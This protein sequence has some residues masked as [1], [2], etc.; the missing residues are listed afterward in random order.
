LKLILVG[1]ELITVKMAQSKLFLISLIAI[2]IANISCRGQPVF[3]DTVHVLVYETVRDAA[4]V[5]TLQRQIEGRING[6][7][8]TTF[9]ESSRFEGF[10]NKFVSV[11]P[12]LREMDKDS[13]VVIA[14][15]RDVLVNN[16]YNDETY[17]NVL[18]DEFKMTFEELTFEHPG[19][20]VVSAE[21][22]CCVV[23]LT[24]AAPGSYFNVD[25]TRNQ[26]ACSSGEP[27]CQWNGDDKAAPWEMFMKNLML[28]RTVAD[29][30]VYDDMYLNA[31]LIAGRAKDLIRV[32]EG[33][34]M[35]KS[36][37]DQA[38]LTDYMFR[39]PDEIML[40]YGQKMFGNN[41]AGVAGLSQEA[42]CIFNKPSGESRL[43]H[44]ETGTT[45]LFVHS[46]G[47]FYECHDSLSNVLGIPELSS[48]E[49][50]LWGT[51]KKKKCNYGP[52]KHGLE[53][54]L[55]IARG[56]STAPTAAPTTVPVSSLLGSLLVGS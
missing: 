18:A 40:D 29:R 2:S 56:A 9:G 47:G 19:A 54:A 16:P 50:Q 33:T 26:L 7:N 24:H 6:L 45:P 27:D 34:K 22:Q 4:E 10:G 30:N 36:E 20:I 37:D 5:S 3:D 21:A 48:A 1:N 42:K 39:H 13:L 51:I 52:K 44:S 23:A 12:I 43:Y 55:N 46:P 28:T 17:M 41:R 15:S 35:G 25:G 53:S 14:D 8:L 49:R 32:I 11:L 38:V 31:G